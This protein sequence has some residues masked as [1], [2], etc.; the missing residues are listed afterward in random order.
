MFHCDQLEKF[1]HHAIARFV[2]LRPATPDNPQG[3]PLVKR[4]QLSLD[5]ATHPVPGQY[6]DFNPDGSFTPYVPPAK[7]TPKPAPTAAAPA[8]SAPSSAATAKPAPTAAAAE[9]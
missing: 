5:T 2:K 3:L 4:V 8:T 9:E 6:Y 7:P 1:T